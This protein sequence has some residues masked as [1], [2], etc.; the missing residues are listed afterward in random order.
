MTMGVAIFALLYL[1]ASPLD[2]G[3]SLLIPVLRPRDAQ[4]LAARIL[5]DD[6]NK[7]FGRGD[8]ITLVDIKDTF[9]D[10]RLWGHC[11]AAFLS[12]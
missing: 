9:V 3:R 7:A 10:W 6:P 12:S 5:A 8:K 1:P 4:V 2:G 11:A